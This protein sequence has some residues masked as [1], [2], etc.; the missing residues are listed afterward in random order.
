VADYDI[1][2]KADP[3]YAR[4]IFN[5]GFAY[6]LADML[7]KALADLSQAHAFDPTDPYTVLTLDIVGQKSKLHSNM[8]GSAASS[9]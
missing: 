6:F 8:G 3:K 7:P 1:A 4:A 5:R 9:T 2:I